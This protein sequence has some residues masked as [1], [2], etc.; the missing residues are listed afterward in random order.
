[1]FDFGSGVAT[2]TPDQE[3]NF[4]KARGLRI[5]GRQLADAVPFI[6]R[7]GAVEDI[8]VLDLA[9]AEGA[10]AVEFAARGAKRVV[11]IEGRDLY[12][13]RAMLVAEAYGLENVSF[14]RGD[15]R[16]IDAN[17]PGVFDLVLFLGILH[18]LAP[19][20]FLTTLKRLRSVTGDTLVL[21]T[22]TSKQGCEV[23]FGKRLSEELDIEGGYRGRLYMEH[24]ESATP[25]QRAARVRNSLD[26]SFS[27]WAREESLIH[28]LRD[29]GFTH[30]SKLMHPNPFGDPVNEF[31]VLYVCR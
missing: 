2:L 15:V 22:H 11:G 5:I 27:F 13:Q 1:L 4:T 16:D 23:K 24:P 17:D 18:H 9:C 3:P 6:T 20:V 14:R 26:N 28:G 19:D 29:A 25:E 12:V 31:R 10:H 7:K 30:I 21:Y 8:S